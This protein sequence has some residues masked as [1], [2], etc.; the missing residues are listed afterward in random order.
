MKTR[1]AKKARKTKRRTRTRP[2]QLYLSES[3]YADLQW[4]TE[5]RGCSAAELVRSWIVRAG[6][7]CAGH[8]GARSAEA[9]PRQL[10]IASRLESST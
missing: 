8:D 4:L 9:D 6:A 5:R 3:E 1:T 7:A 10:T 2:V